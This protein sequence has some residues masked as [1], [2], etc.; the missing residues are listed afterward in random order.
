MTGVTP[1]VKVAGQSLQITLT[2]VLGFDVT[3][4]TDP[5]KNQLGFAA[6]AH[7][8]TA[9]LFVDAQGL[10]SLISSSLSAA[11]GTTITI[12]PE[13]DAFETATTPKHGNSLTFKVDW[14]HTFTDV[15]LPVDFGTAWATS[16]M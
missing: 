15:K 5:A 16:R 7:S 6:S 8:I 4:D 1:T 9:P 10:A 11:T 2:G 12:V 14:S 3:A 13:Y